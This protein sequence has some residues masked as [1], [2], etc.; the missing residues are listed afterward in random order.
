MNAPHYSA[1]RIRAS[2]IA[3]A[4]GKGI[5]APLSF[6]LILV[7]AAVMSRAEYASYIA[8]VAVLDIGVVLGTLGVDWVTQTTL[9]G[10]RVRGNAAQ[11]RRAVL[12]LGVLPVAPYLLLAG[13]L[14]TFAPQLSSALG[15][16]AAPE[17]LRLYA[18]VLAIEGPTRLL[19]DSL[20]AALLLQRTAQVS[21]VLR[22]VVTFSIVAAMALAGT[23]IEAVD[24]A[25][26]EILA[27]AVALCAAVAA[28]AWFLW[29]ERPRGALDGAIGAWVGWHSVRFAAHAYGS[30]LM[31]LQ[32]GTDVMTALIA[33]YLGVD[34]TA[35]FGFAVRL[36]ETARRY[37][38]MDMFWGVLRP[39]AI[40][41]FEDSGRDMRTLVRDVNR[42]VEANLLVV[43]AGLVVAIAAGDGVVRLLSKGNVEV[44][45]LLLLALVPLLATHTV[46]RAVELVAYV[47]N[48]SADFVRASM[49]SLLAPPA[50]A[51][52]LLATGRVH[53]APLAVLAVDVLFI[54][55]TMSAMS[56]AGHAVAFKRDRWVRLAAAVAGGGLAG[57]AAHAAVPG[58]VGTGIALAVGLCVYGALV[59]GLRVVD[60]ED[61]AWLAAVLKNRGHG[62]A[63]V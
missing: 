24:V 22:V 54:G 40:G 48:R 32:V 33:R 42:M 21:Q 47:C 2:M 10:I 56:R 11:L 17:V 13:A 44:P 52:A 60:H 45:A 35:A 55:V 18:V 8:T 36:V 6:L 62:R 12:L 51:G 34:A 37:L 3:F 26:A 9:A 50:I 4:I 25:R 29:T 30:L 49:V 59:A 46:R 7:L 31:M 23:P 58:S 1:R 38:P 53:A 19:R 61:R 41:R 16:V 28:V 5:S 15:A 43:G 63:G 57:A 39:A 27:A 14:W 20:M